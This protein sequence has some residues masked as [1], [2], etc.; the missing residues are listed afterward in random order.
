[1]RNVCWHAHMRFAEVAITSTEVA[2][3]RARNLKRDALAELLSR[4]TPSEVAVVVG[5]LTGQ[6]RQGRIGVGWRTLA[7]AEEAAPSPAS[8]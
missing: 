2:S 5:F 3:M 6:L 7:A 1:M 4:A 8:R